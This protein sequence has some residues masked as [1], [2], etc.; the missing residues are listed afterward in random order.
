MSSSASVIGCLEPVWSMPQLISRRLL[1][2]PEM[3]TNNGTRTAY[4]VFDP[5]MLVE[6]PDV[7]VGDFEK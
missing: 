7:V 2:V 5:T 6:A 3:M 4:F 1:D